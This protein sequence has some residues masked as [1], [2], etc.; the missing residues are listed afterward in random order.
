MQITHFNSEGRTHPLHHFLKFICFG[1]VSFSAHYQPIPQGDLQCQIAHT[2]THTQLIP[3]CIYTHIH[4]QFLTA[5]IYTHIHTYIYTQFLIAYTHTYMHNSSGD[6]NIL[7][8]SPGQLLR[9]ECPC[10][11]NEELCMYVC[12]YIC[13]VGLLPI[14]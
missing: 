12:V 3:H 9:C 10:V 11:C 14:T 7:I 13:S 2:H 4:T 5:Y 8:A 6:T 1:T